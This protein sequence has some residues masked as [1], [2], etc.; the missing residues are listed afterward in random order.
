MSSWLLVHSHRSTIIDNVSIMIRGILCNQ[1]FSF[2]QQYLTNPI[3]SIDSISIRIETRGQQSRTLSS[4]WIIFILY[5]Y[6]HCLHKKSNQENRRTSDMVVKFIVVELNKHLH[7]YFCF[8]FICTQLIEKSRAFRS[9]RFAFFSNCVYP[10]RYDDRMNEN[11]L[12]YKIVF[13][14]GSCY[15]DIF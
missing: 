1:S 11:H 8:R 6:S 5:S 10:Y 3:E 9:Q 14:N 2:E 4:P 15:S 13:V 12:D 7:C